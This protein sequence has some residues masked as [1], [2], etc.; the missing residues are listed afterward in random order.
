MHAEK[1][2]PGIC[3]IVLDVGD[4]YSI[5]NFGLDDEDQSLDGIGVMSYLESAPDVFDW[6]TVPPHM[7]N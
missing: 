2:I 5:S 3:H 4:K 7:R 1:I 6:I